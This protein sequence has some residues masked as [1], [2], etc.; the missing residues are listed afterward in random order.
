M[1]FDLSLVDLNLVLSLYFDCFILKFCVCD[2]YENHLSIMC[3][4]MFLHHSFVVSVSVFHLRPIVT[5]CCC[6]GFHLHLPCL[7]IYHLSFSCHALFIQLLN[8]D[9]TVRP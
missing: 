9:L 7:E 1:S 3:H 2:I 4:L 5:S 6:C 8:R